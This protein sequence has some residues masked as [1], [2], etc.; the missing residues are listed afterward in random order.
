[1]DSDKHLYVIFE[2]NPEWF[3]E[4]TGRPSP[5]PSRF[6]SVNVKA[7]ERRADGVVIAE[8]TSEPIFV[9]EIQMQSDEGIY[10]RVVIEM[11]IIQSEHPRREVEGIIIF[12]TREMDPRTEPWIQVVSTY[13]LDEMLEKLSGRCPEHP[14]VAVFQ[15]LVEKNRELLGRNAARY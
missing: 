4:L 7:I 3:F 10:R 11:A 15:P 9:T 2:V 13:Y 1:M 5:G 6:V 8:A 12:A 14:L